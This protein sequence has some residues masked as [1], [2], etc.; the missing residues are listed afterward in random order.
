MNTTPVLGNEIQLGD[1]LHLMGRAARVAEIRPY[2]NDFTRKTWPE[3]G[4]RIAMLDTGL[5]C[6]LEPNARYYITEKVSA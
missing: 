3:G 6:T 5:C 4:V 2:E 1:M